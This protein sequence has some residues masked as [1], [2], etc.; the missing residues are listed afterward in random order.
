M[1][2][3][4][5]VGCT[6]TLALFWE[7]RRE[8]LLRLEKGKIVRMESYLVFGMLIGIAFTFNYLFNR[9]LSWCEEPPRCEWRVVEKHP[10]E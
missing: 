2:G 6:P 1:G 3:F 9:A 8:F 4:M 5:V 10:A 7:E